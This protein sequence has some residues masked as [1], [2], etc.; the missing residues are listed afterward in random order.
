MQLA[1]PAPHNGRLDHCSFHQE[2]GD[3]FGSFE[4]DGEVWI[5]YTPAA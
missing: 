2:G 5:S 1:K 3:E 4:V